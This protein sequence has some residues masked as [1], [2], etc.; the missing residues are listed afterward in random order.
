MN[1]SSFKESLGCFL[2]EYI[3]IG[4]AL[5]YLEFKNYVWEGIA[6]TKWYDEWFDGIQITA[7]YL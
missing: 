4:G 6:A 2:K 1:E 7:C 5:K 3:I